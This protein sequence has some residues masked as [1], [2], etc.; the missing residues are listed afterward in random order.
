MERLGTDYID[1]YQLHFW[2]RPIDL[3]LA[4]RDVSRSS[5]RRPDPHVRLEHRRSR[6]RAGFSRLRGCGVVQQGLS[7][8]D[9]GNPELLALCERSTSPAST[10]GLS[11]WAF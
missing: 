10:A 1:L 9:D 5:C 7:V 11:A 8:L 4:A 3:A 2:A 6:C